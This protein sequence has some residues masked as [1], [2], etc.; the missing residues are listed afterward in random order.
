M[1]TCEI[2]YIISEVLVMA[3]IKIS[4]FSDV[5]P[6]SLVERYHRLGETC[7]FRLQGREILKC[8]YLYTELHGVI[9]RKNFILLQ[10]L[11]EIYFGLGF[12]NLIGNIDRDACSCLC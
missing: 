8:W 6:F 11:L 12:I 1:V 4:I 9:S 3:N 2:L 5:A 10:F 7:C